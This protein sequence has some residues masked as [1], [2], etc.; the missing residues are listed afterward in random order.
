M[1]F[2]PRFR[3]TWVA[4]AATALSVGLTGC[5]IDTTTGDTSSSSN[6][7]GQTDFI[8]DNPR[9]GAGRGADGAAADGVAATGSAA[10][11]G[12]ADPSQ[13]P[14]DDDPARAIAEADIIQIDDNK[15]YALSHYSG[16]SIIDISRPDRMSLLGRYRSTGVPFE[17]YLRDGVVYAMFS[18]WETYVYDEAEGTYDYVQTSRIEALDV[19][20]P[21]NIVS[22]GSFDLPGSISDSRIVGDVLYAV[23]FE[24]GACWG[25]SSTPHTTITSLAI[26]DPAAI[27]VVDQLTYEEENALSYGWRRSV[28]VTEDRMYVAGVEWDGTGEG[29]STIQIIDI[30]DPGGALV[31]G[32][33]VEAVGQIQSRWQM[34]E[35]DGILRVISQPGRWRTSAPPGVQTFAVTSSHEIAPLGYTELR[36]PRPETLRSVRFDGDRA[37]AITAEQTDPL[38]T[39][40]LSDPAN[41]AQLGEL[42]MPGWVYHME[43]RGDRVFALGFD[44]AAEGG[45]LHVSLFDV[46]D[47]TTPT[48]LERVAFGGDWSSVAEDQDR[49]HKAFT[50]LDSLG[51]ILVPYSGWLYDERGFECGSYESGIQ[52]IDFT[53]D[54]LTKRGVAPARGRAR[55][56]FVHNERLFAVS[57]ADVSTFD[58]GDRDAPAKIDDFALATIVNNAVVVG[59]VVVRTSADW[60]TSSAKLEVVPL[61]QPDVPSPLG[62]LDLSALAES[63]TEEA[64]YRD[65]I[66]Y[67]SLF[68]HGQHVYLLWPSGDWRSR[69]LAVIDVTD[70]REPSVAGRLDLPLDGYWRGGYFGPV[71]S[72]GESVVQAGSTLVIHN[73]V[74]PI[75][76][77]DEEGRR[78]DPGKPSASLEIIDLSNPRKPAHSASVKL[79]DASGYTGLQ[80]DGT[81]V[82]TSHWVPL[83]DDPSRARFY[84]DR[85]DVSDPSSP[86]VHAP[87]NVPGSLLAFDGRSGRLL[88]VDYTSVELPM[89]SN[90]DCHDQFPATARFEPEAEY[91]W[92]GPGTCRG[93]RHTLKLLDISD[94]GAR[95]RE[96]RP[97]A[98][99]TAI[100]E[101]LAGDGRTFLRTAGRTPGAADGTGRYGYVEGLLVAGDIEDG[102]IELASYELPEQRQVVPRSVNGKRLILSGYDPYSI[103]VLDATDLDNVTFEDK[104]KLSSFPQ[105]V[106]ISG[107]HALCSIGPFGLEVVDLGD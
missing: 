63:A 74:E 86:V 8:S 65:N 44:N 20:D 84:L 3:A 106:T 89:T 97:L 7:P 70:P 17:M 2:L 53:R 19:G 29:H 5:V 14:S 45:S 72:A 31:E 40:D 93:I 99:R 13:P 12:G 9:G 43:P 66:A 18:S 103:S 32:A 35:H 34:D 52:L 58:I 11:T 54:T 76:S 91:D 27:E 69:R 79:P 33:S 30:S 46:S 49:I 77:Y 78:L 48:M 4:V 61:E 10:S 28:S 82:L 64:C 98:D 85:I 71:I 23:T 104:A 95:L 6:A 1:T 81:T 87:V 16:L 57:D 67:A 50:I 36:L 55:R 94:R 92:D 88:T 22:I 90:V 56:A 107:D 102:T 25:C 37:Y 100:T 39:I 83:A 15:L 21:G 60:W 51:T 24:D 42:E 80:I 75:S 105:H 68:T 59:D 47:L 41:P 101:A 62:E 96:E 73:V 26:D 38:F